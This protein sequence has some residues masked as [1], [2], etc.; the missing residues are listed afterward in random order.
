MEIQNHFSY[1]TKLMIYL[2]LKIKSRN[3]QRLHRGTT[4]ISVCINQAKEK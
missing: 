4:E 1:A 3:T 2:S